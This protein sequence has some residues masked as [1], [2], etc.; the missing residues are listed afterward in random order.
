MSGPTAAPFRIACTTWPIVIAGLVGAAYALGHLGWFLDTPLGRVPVLDQRENL[1]LANAIADGAVSAEPFY[2]APGY[3]LLLAVPR[4]LG[5]AAPGLFATALLLGAVLHA[6]NAGLVAHIARTWF[7]ATAGIAAGVLF[8][9][10]PVFV[11]FAV[12][13][14]DATPALT[15]FLA[16]L[17]LLG[18]ELINFGANRTIAPPAGHEGEPAN[19]PPPRPP[20]FD[21]LPRPCPS[22]L[23]PF[24]LPALRW[25]GASLAWAIATAV[26]PNYL[27]VW[28]VLPVLAL[29][30]AKRRAC[31]RSP[32]AA[33]AAAASGHGTP[34]DTI[35]APARSHRLR[36]VV[37]ACAGALIFIALAFWQYHVSGVP[38]FLPAQGAYNLW[39]A[40]QPGA[41]GRYYTQKL[42]LPAAVA[43]R[44]P[45][46]A[47]SMLLYERET[48]RPAA[49]L[50]AANAHWRARFVRQV[51]DHPLAWLR[52]LGRKLYAL[53]NDWE[54]YNNETPAFHFARSPWL[55]WN[56]ISW[57]VVFVLAI[58]GWGRLAAER[59]RLLSSLAL[60]TAACAGSALLFFVSARFR[61]PVAAL[62]T[63]LAGIV[64]AAP[65][66]WRTWRR[67][68]QL[69][70]AASCLAAGGI[71]FS[72]FDE[73]RD[74][75]TFVQDHALLARAASTVGCD[76]LAWHEAEAALALRPDHPDPLRLAVASY[77][78]LLLS[79]AAP[80]TTERQ[81]HSAAAHLLATATPDVPDLR[82]VAAL[83]V[84]RAG[85]HA[86]ALT[87]WR[88][89]GPTPSAIA[90]RL[91]AGDASA[92]AA[93]L[94]DM[95]AE[96]WTQP[97]VR[98]AAAQL[99]VK[100]PPGGQSQPP[101][102]A[103]RTIARL[104]RPAQPAQN[105]P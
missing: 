1:A 13:A 68:H 14:T 22:S 53:L 102:D 18:P 29:V 69:G 54:Q 74:R 65:G 82:A 43:E 78:N 35:G 56:P 58:A 51:T 67:P 79:D 72:T 52:L 4:W 6:I 71:A 98:L 20:P 25:A 77:F 8:A 63:V 12:Q 38:G 93:N 15:F 17:A 55:R 92:G 101:R 40:N 46:R 44:N 49:N 24:P 95:D 105:T 26:R 41:H 87:E 10:D 36:T 34:A 73:V 97:L 64:I 100:P 27:L 80:N 16:G 60:I 2:R 42:A 19:A 76:A 85:D 61:L 7:G 47:E 86:S 59:P 75:S 104:F 84:W 88:R 83:A 3:A 30:C 91:L 94:A 9:L 45:A 32:D 23:V 31:N 39:A 57:G 21:S 28:L 37:S 70:L 96:G 33:S 81:W 90:A 62:M 103:A 50:A 89:L 48:G 5:V 99:G 66:F 11:H